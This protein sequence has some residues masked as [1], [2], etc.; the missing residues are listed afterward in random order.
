MK[1]MLAV[2]AIVCAGKAG[3]FGGSGGAYECKIDPR[4]VMV[5]YPKPR[6]F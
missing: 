1:T 6:G 5:C 2:L 3:A 4:G